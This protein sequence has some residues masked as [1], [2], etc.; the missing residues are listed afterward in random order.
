MTAQPDVVAAPS[1]RRRWAAL[2][3][4]KGR[5][6]GV[7]ARAPAKLRTKLLVAFLAIAALLVLVSALGLQVL[8]QSNARVERL[9]TLQLRSSTYQTLA[10]TAVDLQEMLTVR[11]AG[12]PA[13]TPYT[14]G[15]AL[16]GGQQWLLA[17][18]AVANLLS[19]VELAGNERNF[20]FVPPP[21]EQRVLRR[22]RRDYHT[23]LRAVDRILVL[24]SKGVRAQGREPY[25]RSARTDG[26]R[27]VGV[28][29]RISPIG[30]SAETQALVDTNR[31]AYTSSRNLFVAVSAASVVLALTLGARSLLVVDRSDP[32]HG[33]AAR[34]RSPPAT[35]RGG[36]TCRTATSSARSPP[37]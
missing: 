15:T 34:T 11:Q 19:Q 16:Q 23:V 18:R 31:S 22:I 5:F 24:D 2:G 20:G 9:G 1:T 30:R 14:G 28:A 7:V 4:M 33:G 6:A 3:G 26:R 27:P 13:L 36:S 10:A 29:R 12:T 21:A 8:G 25:V 17:D 32:A 35:S 37:T